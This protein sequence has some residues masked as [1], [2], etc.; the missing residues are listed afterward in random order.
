MVID[1]NGNMYGTASLGG[2]LNCNGI[3]CGVVWEITP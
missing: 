2:N 3:G 1:M